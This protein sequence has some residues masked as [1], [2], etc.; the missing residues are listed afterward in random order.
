M[1]VSLV[2]TRGFLLSN[3]SESGKNMKI[4]AANM[5]STVH[6]DNNNK[7]I[8]ILGKDPTE[9]YRWYYSECRTYR[10]TN[11]HILQSYR[12]NFI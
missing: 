2:N 3:G 10:L 9:G 5:G 4:F 8:S 12:G 6:I 11:L 1:V 7:D